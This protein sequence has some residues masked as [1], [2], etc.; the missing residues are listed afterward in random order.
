MKTSKS[1]Y[2]TIRLDPQ[3]VEWIEEMRTGTN[4]S[5]C[6][7]VYDILSRAK[8]VDELKADDTS[9]LNDLINQ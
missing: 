8:W 9:Q 7:Q 4:R 5:F 2:K 3:L 6:N 1:I